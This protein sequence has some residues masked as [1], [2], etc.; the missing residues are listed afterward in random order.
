MR[1][2]RGQAAVETLVVLP[3]L[4]MLALVCVQALVWAATG[5]QASGAAAA[6]A[7]AA[8]RGDDAGTAARRA[9]PDLL[10]PGLRLERAPGGARISL[11]APSLVPAISEVRVS[12]RV[13][14]TVL[15]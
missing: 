15:P 9:V 6:A 13:V 4:F 14:G 12:D 8:A 11:A 3:V 5:V 10:R 1:G 2:E 7:R